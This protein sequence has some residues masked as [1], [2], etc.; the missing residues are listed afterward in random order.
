MASA[1]ELRMTPS[2]KAVCSFR[3][4]VNRTGGRDSGADFF[5]IV[6]W[7]KQA[8]FVDEYLGKGRK[9]AIEGRLHHRTWET[10]N[11]DKRS[12][13]EVVAYR[14]HALPGRDDADNK[15]TEKPA[16]APVGEEYPF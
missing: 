11:G 2:Q 6:C 3:L 14:V 7:E 9:V 5:D 1:P 4:A 12:A 10:D 8:E 16:S 13:V 15:A